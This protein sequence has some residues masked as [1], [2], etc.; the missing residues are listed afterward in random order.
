[1]KKK[2]A[3]IIA[4]ILMSIGF[5]SIST[6]LILN[7]NANVSENNEDFN[8]IF[9][10][11]SI[12]GNDVYSTA[13]DS[14]K[15][16]ITFTTSELKTLNQTSILTY[17]VTNNSSQ[18]DAEVNVTCVPKEGTTA[19]YTSIKNKLEND[20]TKVSAKSSVNGTL[21][22][23]L[24]KT[25]T[26]SVTEEYTCKLEFNA[27]ER[28]EI[29]YD[30]PTEWT[31]DYTGGEQTFTVPLSGTYKLEVWGAQGGSVDDSSNSTS[32][33]GGYG[34]YS[35][36]II[37][38]KK[39]QIFYIN[40]GGQGTNNCFEDSSDT[41][42]C[43]GG[44]NGGGYG[45]GADSITGSSSG[46][47]ATHIATSSGLLA[48][49]EKNKSAIL[50]VA[51][52]GGGSGYAYGPMPNQT[53]ADSKVRFD[54]IGGSAGGYKGS[55]G[56]DSWGTAYQG[57]NLIGFLGTGATQDTAGQTTN[58]G[59]IIS[60]AHGSFG[61]GGNQ[62]QNCCGGAGG[63]GGFYGGGGSSR[64]HGG[65][66]GGSGYISNVF[67]TEKSMYCYNCTESSEESTKTISTT[68]TSV[69]PTKNCAKQG[70][71]YARITLIK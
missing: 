40:I 20:A 31:F 22:I 18:Y 65:A 30:G 41:S 69:I 21:T 37:Q 2:S 19:K 27:V 34:S 52:G 11:A 26:E 4:I 1:M 57:S 36:G 63:G 33:N 56:L 17:E 59:E 51:G 47:G 67:L 25:A 49:L 44:Y 64:C 48:N 66:G 60:D 9:T 68:C 24:N 7:G 62:Y 12:D 50:M 43:P 6:T 29:G 46:G 14:T 71:G 15:K 13:V 23:T 5:A 61:Q 70:N 53:S 35:S 45:R 3:I 54:G 42:L 28:T 32:V 39:E 55:S 16:I 10:A 8:V 38:M 58:F